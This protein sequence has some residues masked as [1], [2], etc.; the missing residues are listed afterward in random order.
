[1]ET[2]RRDFLDTLML[3]T[4]SGSVALG[5]LPSVLGAGEPNVALPAIADPLGTDVAAQQQ[6]WDT[7]WGSRMTGRLKAVFD[8][9]EL[10]N[11]LPVWRA[12]IWTAQYEA[13]L[14]VPAAQMST[15]LV[16]RHN[17][18]P[19]AL[20]QEYW[21]RYALGRNF[22][23]LNPVTRQPSSR[24][25]AMLGV[26]DGLTEQQAGF[27]LDKFIG[28]G[29]IT[30]ACDLALRVLIVPIIA[31][32]DRVSTDVAYATARAGLIPGVILQPS[33]MFAV[34]RAQEAGA[35][36]FRAG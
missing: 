21:D 8:V 34:I 36:Y 10:E 13:V 7:G 15:A 12:S 32:T 31:A 30:L 18:I 28:R 25:I 5:A 22:S 16:L 2:S 11:G 4:L 1:M 24:N 3:S 35:F 20:K 33:G 17:A 27:A 23:A 9:P 19:M 26:S 29:G 14:Q 6:A